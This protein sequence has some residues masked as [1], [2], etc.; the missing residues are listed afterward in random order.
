MTVIDPDELVDARRKLSQTYSSVTWSSP[1]VNA[2]LQAFEDWFD[3]AKTDAAAAVETAVPGVFTTAQKKK[4]GGLWM[5]RK[6]L[7]ELL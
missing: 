1:E 3:V 5:L 6:A 2:A 7:R 4:I